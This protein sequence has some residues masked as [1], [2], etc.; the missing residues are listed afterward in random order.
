MEFGWGG[1]ILN[2]RVSEGLTGHSIRVTTK[3]E[4]L[5]HGDT[6]RKSVSG[7]D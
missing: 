6:R 1:A 4:G 2:R 3:M 7:K 5:S